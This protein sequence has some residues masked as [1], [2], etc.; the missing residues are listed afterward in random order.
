[1]I[2]YV[3]PRREDYTIREYLELWGREDAERIAVVHYEDLPARRELPA[4]TYVFSALDHLTEAGRKLVAGL[5]ETL[6]RAGPGARVINSPGRTLLRFELLERLHRLGF[7]SHRAARAGGDLT[8]LRYPVFVRDERW[9]TGALSPLLRTPSELTAA[10]GRSIVRGHRLDDLLAV[11]FTDTSDSG[12]TFRKYAAFAVGSAI[13]PRTLAVGRHWM[14]KQ[15]GDEPTESSYREQLAYVFENPHED[16]L[17]R[18]SSAAG[19]EYGRIDYSMKDGAPVT[20]EINLNPTIG[21]GLRPASLAIN[22]ELRALREEAKEH[23]YSRFRAAWGA[24]DLAASSCGIALPERSP[25]TGP[26]TYVENPYRWGAARRALRPARAWIDR[27]AGVLS[28]VL[29]R[30]SRAGRSRARSP[31]P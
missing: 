3:V 4:G 29:I 11:E 14:L 27:V 24:V 16:A 28:P 1:M 10:L 22:L 21:R 17:R 12:G 19:V 18:I 9:H 13:I 31:S 2:H 8:G 20:W 23:F 5:A 15:E 26:V 7:N 25:V 30:V 6:E